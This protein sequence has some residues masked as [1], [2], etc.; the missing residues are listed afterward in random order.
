LTLDLSPYNQSPQIDALNNSKLNITDQRYNET[1]QIIALNNSKVDI[2]NCNPYSAVQN[3]TAHGVQCIPL[4]NDTDTNYWNK[5]NTELRPKEAE[6]ISTGQGSENYPDYH[7]LYNNKTGM[8]VKTGIDN[9]SLY[10]TVD[11]RDSLDLEQSNM[12]LGD[13][14]SVSDDTLAFDYY[15]NKPRIRWGTSFL[16]ERYR[17]AGADLGANITGYR[18]PSSPKTFN[19]GWWDNRAWGDGVFDSYGDYDNGV[20]PIV[21]NAVGTP[22]QWRISYPTN[23]YSDNYTCVSTSR[24]CDI[25][26]LF[27]DFPTTGRLHIMTDYN[28]KNVAYCE[29][30]VIYHLLFSNGVEVPYP[31]TFDNFAT[32]SSYYPVIGIP[33]E[34]FFVDVQVDMSDGAMVLG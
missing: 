14:N 12:I 18:M 28:I 3:A 32:L 17:N 9:D 30:S 10:L 6:T 16:V 27:E 25:D 29:G 5:T 33:L 34:C 19:E 8:R 11:G 20:V 24:W 31:S 22:D 1:S 15:N 13:A 7:F 4:I 21:F 2:F 26:F 23:R